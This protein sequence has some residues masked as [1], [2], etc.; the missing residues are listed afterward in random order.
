VLIDITEAVEAEAPPFCGTKWL[1]AEC[2]A[3][4]EQT[5]AARLDQRPAN[6]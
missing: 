1:A 6:Q 4:G 3:V 2:C 5:I